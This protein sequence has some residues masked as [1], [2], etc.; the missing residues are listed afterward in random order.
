V[1][2]VL[3]IIGAAACCAAVLATGVGARSS[4]VFSCKGTFSNQTYA[5]V[6]VPAKSVCHLNTVTVTGGITIEGQ[7]FGSTLTVGGDVLSQ[8][9]K[10]V[11]IDSSNINGDL[12]LKDMAGA[13][14]NVDAVSIE[15]NDIK[16]TLVVKR[17]SGGTG[18]FLVSTDTVG[19]VENVSLNVIN[20]DLSVSAETVTGKMVV[21]SNTG[22]GTKEVDGNSSTVSISCTGNQKPFESHGNTAPTV[23]GQCN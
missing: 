11:Q 20:G 19:G 16:G 12:K 15:V 3:L 17:V 8:G 6:D 22:P 14:A 9:G 21:G 23:S 10:V 2:K 13:P 1:G 7:L 4:A 5:A 18:D